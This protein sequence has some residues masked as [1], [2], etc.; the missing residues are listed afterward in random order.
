MCLVLL[1]LVGS[2][3]LYAQQ[4]TKQNKE[5]VTIPTEVDIKN[6]PRQKINAKVQSKKADRRQKRAETKRRFK[7]QFVNAK[8]K[9]MRKVKYLSIH[10]KVEAINQELLSKGDASRASVIEVGGKHYIN[11]R[12]KSRVI[13]DMVK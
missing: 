10:N 4:S 8:G 6:S 1:F 12:P 11:M 7:A 9:K 13:F 5:K 2:T 3:E